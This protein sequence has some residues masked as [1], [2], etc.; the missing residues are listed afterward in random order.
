VD[1]LMIGATS[2][3]IVAYDNLSHLQPWLSDALCRLCTGGGLSKRE[4]FSDAEEVLLDAQRPVIVNG[5]GEIATRSDLLDRAIML[6]L[7]TIE[8]KRC[9]AEEEFWRDFEAARPQILGALCDAV[10]GA[11]ANIGQVKLDRRPRMADFALWITAAESALGWEPG[12]FMRSYTGNRSESRELAIEASPVGALLRTIAEEGFEGTT[13]ELLELLNTRAG[14]SAQR[15]KE[16]PKNARSL[17]AHITRLAPDLRKLGY[18]VERAG[19]GKHQSMI[20]LSYVEHTRTTP[21]TPPTP[22]L[23][24]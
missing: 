11:L 22:H 12:A 13:R 3:W 2:S 4:L 19:R 16:W 7:P 5:I 14:E 20:T 17:A 15:Q 10:A 24:L 6:E 9:I 18:T 8:E 23:A 21:R 1:D